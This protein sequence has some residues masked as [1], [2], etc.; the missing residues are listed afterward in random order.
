MSPRR[1]QTSK[2]KPDCTEKL[3]MT[4]IQISNLFKTEEMRQLGEDRFL[5]QLRL[6]PIEVE[7][8]SAVC[9]TAGKQS[10]GLRAVMKLWSKLS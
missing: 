10:V 5:R 6:V 8:G 2:V 7:G 9:E 1:N 3:L 4:E